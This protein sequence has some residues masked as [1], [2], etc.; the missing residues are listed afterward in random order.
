MWMIRKW[1]SKILY[2]ALLTGPNSSF[3]K[4]GQIIAPI[5]M[6]LQYCTDI[7]LRQKSFIPID[8]DAKSVAAS[9]GTVLKQNLSKDLKNVFFFLLHNPDFSRSY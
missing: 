1:N 4:P 8:D 2:V 9:P 6:M 7:H 5:K 3:L